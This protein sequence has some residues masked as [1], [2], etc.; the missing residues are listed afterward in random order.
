MSHGSFS[1]SDM[2][3]KDPGSDLSFR[4]AGKIKDF[5]KFI[6][7]PGFDFSKGEIELGNEITGNVKGSLSMHIPLLDE[8][9][10]KHVSVSGD[11]RLTDI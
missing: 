6:E 11:L 10:F 7:Q 5:H 8:V 2:R 3:E 9:E 4:V 1:I